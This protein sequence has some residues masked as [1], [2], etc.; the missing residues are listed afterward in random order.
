[1]KIFYSYISL[2]VL[3]FISILSSAQSDGLETLQDQ[4]VISPGPITRPMIVEIAPDTYFINEYGMNAMYLLVGEK[5]ALL[6]DTGTGFCDLKGIVEGLT[7]LPY[8]VALTHGHPDHAGGMGQFDVVY[9]NMDDKDMATNIPYEQR[10]EY[11][12]IMHNMNI[13]Y[14]D[15]W[16]YTEENVTRYNGQP[17]LRPLG[18]EQ[19]FDL[20]NRNVT[21]YYAPGHSPGSVT[22]LDEKTKILFSGDAA[23]TN[24]GT[25]LPVSTTLKYLIHLQ[26]LGSKYDR[27][28]TGHISYAGTI[29]VYS[30][31]KTALD[32]II[33]AFR[34]ILRGDAVIEEVPNHL[35]PERT[36]IRA[37]YGRA[38][39]GFNPE[40]LWEEGEEHIIP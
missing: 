8:D 12:E 24:V 28:F 34:S 7:D 26:E 15:V 4:T 6:I 29:D 19:I 14:K 20:G 33:E 32:D 40:K 10:V 36:N 1:M 3:L 30:Q 16:G 39:V 35:F 2:I 9:L 5:R 18:D 17:E 23:N 25:S 13:G 22:F 27:M 31:K 11:D 21:V 38:Q 37:M